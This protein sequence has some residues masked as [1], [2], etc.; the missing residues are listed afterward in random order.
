[1]DNDADN[2]IAEAARLLQ[3]G[4]TKDGV[5]EG[6]GSGNIIIPSQSQNCAVSVQL[7]EI[8]TAMSAFDWLIWRRK[9]RAN[10]GSQA[11][12]LTR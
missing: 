3:E 5:A 12:A 1:M 2:L 10:T 4:Y 7:V 11:P 6:D 9:Q 8:K